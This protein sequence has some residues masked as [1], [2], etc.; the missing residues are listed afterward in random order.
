MSVEFHSN[1]F[2]IRD[3][4]D[5]CRNCGNSDNLYFAVALEK[6]ATITNTG[7]GDDS[8]RMSLPSK[9]RIV[10][11][12]LRTGFMCLGITIIPVLAYQWLVYKTDILEAVFAMIF[13]VISLRILAVI[14]FPHKALYSES[15]REKAGAFYSEILRTVIFSPI[16]AFWYVMKLRTPG[17]NLTTLMFE[18]SLYWFAINLF[19]IGFYVFISYKKSSRSWYY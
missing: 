18:V 17:S 19:I 4:S 3:D 16:L 7:Q 2:G 8:M 11:E 5:C 12:M 1:V 6:E 13:L 15:R 10:S 9:Q 14:L